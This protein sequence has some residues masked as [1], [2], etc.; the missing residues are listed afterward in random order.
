MADPSL[1]ACL[2]PYGHGAAGTNAKSTIDMVENA[3]HRIDPLLEDRSRQSSLAPEGHDGDDDGDYD[4]YV[5]GQESD[6]PSNIPNNDY[7]P[8]LQLRFDDWRKNRMGFVL[9]T[10]P[11]CDIVLPKKE[12]LRS[13]AP[14]QCV[15]TFDSHGRLIVRD[16]QERSKNRRGTA[17]MYMNKGGQKRLNFTWIL[18]GDPFTELNKPIILA[19]HDNLQFQIVAAQHDISSP[20][21]QENLALFA[22]RVATDVHDLTLGG[23]GFDCLSSTAAASG[24]QTPSTDAILLKNGELGIGAQAVVFRLWDASTGDDY[25]SKEPL[26]QKFYRRLSAEVQLLSQVNHVSPSRT[27]SGSG[28]ELTLF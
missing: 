1:I 22:N 25:A 23:L 10:S 13:L 7:T 6:H 16:L 17:V 8:G 20:Q 24:A 5:Y 12:S 2:Y 9:G 4:D 21:Y 3:S 26:A 15:I 18:G 27:F 28:Q 11:S 19:L 14:R